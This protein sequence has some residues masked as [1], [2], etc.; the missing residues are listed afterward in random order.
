MHISAATLACLNGVYEVEPGEGDE[1]DPYLREH[2]VQ[3]YLIKQAEPLR[4]RRRLVSRPRYI[5]F[6]SNL[7]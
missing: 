7:S 1:R 3:T 2:G 5:I 6:K 4:P